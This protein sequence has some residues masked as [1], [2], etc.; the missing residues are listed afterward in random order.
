M[1]VL[2][3]CFQGRI[4]Q[5]RNAAKAGLDAPPLRVPELARARPSGAPPPGAADA[6]G[7]CVWGGEGLPELLNLAPFFAE[8]MA[9]AVAIQ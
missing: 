3:A 2:Q 1:C 4:T 5:R 7:V 8:E 9:F 6:G